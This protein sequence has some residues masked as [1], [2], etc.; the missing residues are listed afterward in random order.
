MVQSHTSGVETFFVFVAPESLAA[1]TTLCK[2]ALTEAEDLRS[3]F[4][5]TQQISDRAGERTPLSYI[6][7][8]SYNSLFLLPVY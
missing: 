8:I 3:L 5:G 7:A 2:A 4:K 1:L 6:P